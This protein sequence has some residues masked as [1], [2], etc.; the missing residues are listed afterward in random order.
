[1]NKDQW[2][3]TNSC[4]YPQ[5]TKEKS[6]QKKRHSIQKIYSDLKKIYMDRMP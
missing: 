5:N 4:I 2:L 1:M 6:T 3:H